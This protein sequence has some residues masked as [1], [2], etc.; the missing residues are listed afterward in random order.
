[1]KNII[2]KIT[3]YILETFFIVVAFI[4]IVAFYL[5]QSEPTEFIYYNF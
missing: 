5:Q 3:F 1:M 2:K 4:L